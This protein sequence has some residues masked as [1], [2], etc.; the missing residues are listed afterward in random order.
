MIDFS[1]RRNEL[2]PAVVK[3]AEAAQSEVRRRHNQTFTVQDD[4]AANLDDLILDLLET[5]YRMFLEAQQKT[6]GQMITEYLKGASWTGVEKLTDIED[7]QANANR[8]F[9]DLDAMF[10]S[11]AQSRRSRAGGSF[12]RH[13][14]FLLDALGLPFEHGSNID[15]GSPDFL[16]PRTE[17]YES[18]PA[19]VVLITAKRTLRERWRQIIIEGFKTPRYLL[20]TI[21]DS[22]SEANLNRMAQ[23]R[24]D[25]VVPKSVIE[26]TPHY[27]NALNVISFAD[28]YTKRILPSSEDW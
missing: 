4:L 13:L 5:E 28:M 6:G 22:A 23:H 3:L 16:L 24:I 17:L 27:A 14:I 20:A 2:M 8:I 26:A 19:S 12:E 18:N 25:L 21:D 1:A 9:A 15:G 11:F 10:M 7:A